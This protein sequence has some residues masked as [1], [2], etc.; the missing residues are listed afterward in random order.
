MTL[1][2]ILGSDLLAVARTDSEAATLLTSTIDPRD[3]SFILGATNPDLQ[4]LNDVMI[5][6]ESD[7]ENGDFLQ[8]IEDRWIDRAGLKLFDDAVKD[9]I[10]TSV[11][12]DKESLISEYLSSVRGKSNSESRAIAK[13]LTGLE[14]C[15]DWDSPRTREGF[16][17]YQGGCECAINRALAYAPYADMLWME[18]KLPDYQQ[19]KDFAQ[20][21]HAVWP[22][23]K[24]V[25]LAFIAATS[26]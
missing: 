5:A 4:P 17:R 8:A 26:S 7:G 3:H 25:P 22:E 15:W 9:A 2:T 16:Y 12:V 21:I 23:Q 13:A 20:G 18:S 6:A 11:Q 10:H 19:A 24:F 1:L 14:I